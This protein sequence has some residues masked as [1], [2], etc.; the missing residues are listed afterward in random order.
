MNKEK[1]LRGVT[2]CSTIRD[3]MFL[4]RLSFGLLVFLV[5]VP[6][7]LLMLLALDLPDAVATPGGF[8]LLP[9]GTPRLFAHRG[10][11]LLFP[12]NTL[13]AFLNS[14]AMGADVLDMDVRLTRDG[15]AVAVHDESIERLVGVDMNIASTNLSELQ[16]YDLA[17]LWTMGGITFPYRGLGIKILTLEEM[18]RSFPRA[19]LNIELK[20]PGIG[21]FGSGGRL[22]REVCRLLRQYKATDRV[23]VMSFSDMC[24]LKFRRTC[25]EVATAPGPLG[26]LP[27]ILAASLG[28]P[29]PRALAPY[30]ALQPPL[31]ITTQSLVRTMHALNLGVHVWT[32][33]S[34]SDIEAL[35]AIHVDG[36]M[37]DRLDVLLETVPDRE[38]M[39]IVS[40]EYLANLAN[41]TICNPGV[42][43]PLV[44]YVR[45]GCVN[46]SRT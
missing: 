27:A 38:A 5:F 19:K 25:P 3:R 37:S 1:I 18:L 8:E 13:F 14:A 26:M 24:W 12:E 22:A 39:G 17:A 45:P 30:S 20:L 43:E 31:A 33:D 15:H 35:T 10:S 41:G 2:R 29:L 9:S 34:P 16:A 42:D 21:L 7:A 4:L 6:S 44:S 40:T 36:I 46:H 32:V 23:I 28:L 11:T